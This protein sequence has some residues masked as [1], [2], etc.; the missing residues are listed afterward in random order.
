MRTLLTLLVSLIGLS[1]SAQVSFGQADKF[2][3]GW[4]FVLND[5]NAASKPDYDD[6]RWRPMELPHDWSVESAPSQELASCTGY[7]PGGIGWYRKTFTVADDAARHYIYFEGV[8]NRSDVYLNGHHLGHRPNGYVSFMYD[9]T[10][11]LNKG[12][13]NVIAVRVDHSRYA[14]S[15]WYTGSGIYR[16]V[17]LI[18]APDVHLS[19]WGVA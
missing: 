17:Y 1:A 4:R 11:Y 7:L 13:D 12:G 9:L 16:D 15:R 5:D 3:T 6:S 8:Y 14:D 19:Q 2:N 18:S 10:P